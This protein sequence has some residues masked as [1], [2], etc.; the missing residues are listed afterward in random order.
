MTFSYGFF[1]SY[2]CIILYNQLNCSFIYFF[3]LYFELK[4]AFYG[5]GSEC[6]WRWVVH[7]TYQRQRLKVFQ[8]FKL[9]TFHSESWVPA[10]SMKSW[11][12]CAAELLDIRMVSLSYTN[13]TLYTSNINVL[14]TVQVSTILNITC[15]K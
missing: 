13:G 2:R 6:W 4:I 12:S 10:T 15:L 7:F 9:R 11:R 3:T 5:I 1:T 14:Y 8:Q